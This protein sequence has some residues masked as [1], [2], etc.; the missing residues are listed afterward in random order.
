M[1]LVSPLIL[2]LLAF[3]PSGIWS[4]STFSCGTD[5]LWQQQLDQDTELKQRHESLEKKRADFLRKTNASPAESASPVSYTLPVV[6][7]IIHQNGAENITDAQVQQGIQH[8]NAAFANS[9][10]YD[11]GNGFSTPFQFCL[12]T[13]TPDGLTSTG[14]NRVESPLTYVVKETEDLSLKNLS[15]W[16]PTEYINIWLVAEISSQ[17]SGNGVAGYAYL[18]AAH[19]GPRD[20]LVVE[21]RWFGSAPA[22]SCVAI[23]EMGHYLGLYHTFQGGC[24]ND[25]CTTDGD[26]VCDTPPDQSTAWL[27]CNATQNSCSTDTNSGFTSDQN[28]MTINYMDYATLSCYSAFTAGQSDRM[29][30]FLL[31]TRASLLESFGCLDPCPSA[32]VTAAFALSTGPTIA[33]GTPVNFINTSSNATGFQWLIDNVPFSTAQN[34]S[35]LFTTPGSYTLKLIASGNQPNCIDHATFQVDVFC[36]LD[37]AF[38]IDPP[39]AP[40]PG[41]TIT[42]VATANTANQY[43]WTVNGL[44]LSTTPTLL[45]TIPEPGNYS[46]CLTVANAY[47]QMSQCRNVFVED[48]LPCPNSFFQE[49]GIPSEDRFLWMELEALTD[50]S[51]LAGGLLYNWNE[52]MSHLAPDGSVLNTWL[53]EEPQYNHL[54]ELAPTH[55]NSA[56]GLISTYPAPTQYL[57]FAIFKFDPVLGKMTWSKRLDFNSGMST[58]LALE[59][60]TTH[61]YWVNGMI[62]RPALP[63]DETFLYRFDPLTGDVLSQQVYSNADVPY[64]Y[65]SVTHGDRV[66]IAG[67]VKPNQNTG[68]EQFGLACFSADGN[69]LWSKKY[70]WPGAETLGRFCDIQV[71]GDALVMVGYFSVDKVVILKTDLNGQEI[72]TRWFKSKMFNVG[73]AN[74]EVFNLQVLPTG[75]WLASSNRILSPSIIKYLMTTLDKQGNYLGTKILQ[76]QKDFAGMDALIKDQ[77]LYAVSGGFSL[78]EKTSVLMR[79]NLDFD[80]SP[81]CGMVDTAILSP[82]NFS[83]QI[84]N[85]SPTPVAPPPLLIQ[86]YPLKL[87]PAAVE[88]TRLCEVVH[89]NEFCDNGIDDDGDGYVDC[90]DVSDCPCQSEL[91][92]CYTTD[93]LSKGLTGRLAWNSDALNVNTISTPIVANLNPGKDTIPEVIVFQG[94]PGA[95]NDLSNTLLI[96]RGDGANNAA[97]DMLSI[98][99]NVLIRPVNFP[100]VG[101]VNHDGIPELIVACAD[102]FIRVF[103]QFQPGANPAMALWL[104]S[105]Q[106]VDN[107]GQ[108]P[109]LADFDQD[110]ISE[111]YAGMQVFKF[112]FSNPASP[113]LLRLSGPNLSPYGRI[114]TTVTTQ[115]TSSP[116]AADLLKPIDCG[117]DPDCDGLEIAAGNV[118]YSVDLSVVDGDPVQIKAQLDLNNLAPNQLFSDGYTSVADIDLDGNLDVLVSGRRGNQHG[119]YVW[120][121]TGLVRFFEYPFTSTR[122]GG[123]VAVA[124]V[125]DD[126]LSGAAQDYPE[127]LTSCGNYLVCFNLNKAILTPTEPWWWIELSA[128]LS[129][130]LGV[131]TFD[132]NNDH[133]PE[134]LLRDQDGLRVLYGGALPYPPGVDGAR[135][136]MQFPMGSGTIDE[137]PVVADLD[138]DGQAEIAITGHANPG[139]PPAG[140]GSGRLWVFESDP[141]TGGPWLAARPVWNQF[142]YF[143]LNVN[144]DLSIPKTQQSPHLELPGLGSGKRPFNQFLAQQPFLDTEYNPYLPLP[145]ASINVETV[146]CLGDSLLIKLNICNQGDASL[147]A[148]TPLQLYLGDPAVNG[149]SRLPVTPVLPTNIPAAHCTKMDLSIPVQ[150]SSQIVII[151]NDNGS[152]PLPF[153]LAT[154]LPVTGVLECDYSNN[155]ASFSTPTLPVLDLGPDIEVC[156]N[157]IWTFDAGD[158]FTSYRWSTFSEEQ[159]ETVYT[160]GQYWVET[161]DW[162]G[163]IHTDTVNVHLDSSTVIDLGVDTFLCDGAALSFQ[164][165]GFVEYFWTPA[166]GLSCSDCPNPVA[167]PGN[168]VTY[169]LLA[170]TALGCYSSDSIRVEIGIPVFTTID[171]ALCPGTSFWWN[172]IEILAGA[173]SVFTIPLSTGCDSTILIQ[174]GILPAL[175]TSENQTICQGDSLLIFGNW[176]SN[177]G[178]YQQS[179]NAQNGCDST[180]QIILTI[181]PNL[182]TSENQTICQGDSLL[183]FGNWVSN[184]GVF[185]QSF[186]AL[187]GCDSTH[188]IILYL[189]QFPDLSLQWEDPS[190]FDERDGSIEIIDAAPEF[191]YSLDGTHFQTAP[192][193]DNLPA[194]IYTVQ[195]LDS[196]GCKKNETVTLEQADSIALQMPPDTNIILGQTIALTPQTSNNVVDFKWTPVESLNCPTCANPFAHPLETTTYTLNVQDQNGCSLL[197]QTTVWVKDVSVYIPNVF[198]PLSP[199]SNQVFG[200]FASTGVQQVVRMEIYDRWGAL[201][202]RKENFSADGQQGWDGNWRATS[203][204]PG[205]YVYAITIALE[206]GQQVTFSGDVTL[207]R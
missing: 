195:I 168:S 2:T 46:I 183:I 101:D 52:C 34:P 69:L 20:G 189:K 164:V 95:N 4:Q 45:L 135:N 88:K 31:N 124:N 187:N 132:L 50:G 66:Y 80:Y 71:D 182:Q 113:Q 154:G 193:F 144:D 16:D 104:T 28:D 130:S 122:G 198:K 35:Y 89:C 125:Y 38:T 93:T 119:V 8:L 90:F 75:Y 98:P 176:V 109:F 91:P 167:M 133:R 106:T 70:A 40:K 204:P 29:V 105:D 173:S 197:G 94:E 63:A 92:D 87:T 59:H 41:A 148:G 129:G 5:Q 181:L 26:K 42:C 82:I 25:D 117:G 153:Q 150:W 202:F 206:T 103:T 77:Y 160:P 3:A 200:V 162:C 17:S 23:H 138:N 49:Y 180:H 83:T 205:V 194:G 61:E 159:Q 67:F 27:P 207:I 203:C 139:V 13:R 30:F 57:N 22:N 170:K 33:A 11:G 192:R 156:Q 76:F 178:V 137:Y 55:D 196:I 136:W 186:T 188:Q 115:F 151:V 149:A 12:A 64:G 47:C 127:M 1:R 86:N 190:C 32:P 128:D 74:G 174:T 184:S 39:L 110:G 7:H 172:G 108:R 10:Y 62:K 161:L 96:F 78:P 102:Q 37:P 36:N 60:P 126:K 65:A 24:Y 155:S 111:I 199:G 140:A 147:P 114:N 72:W 51:L 54:I 48:T 19:G 116:V 15:R 134:I 131:S 152:L 81:L 145:D 185:Q 191:T 165:P 107:W 142:S 141:L 56:I 85:L 166:S 100:V 21:A 9:G 163:Q 58:R 146:S 43:D 120:N 68:S 169:Q 6:V 44:S 143:M 179:F 157:G 18:P 118:I 177:S 73:Y 79:L 201:I 99:G 123:M 97:P 175:Q 158:G 14:I 84:T 53:V 112:D 171:T 121:K